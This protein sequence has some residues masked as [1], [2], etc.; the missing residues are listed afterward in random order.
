MANQS[1]HRPPFCDFLE[2]YLAA[3]KPKWKKSNLIDQRVGLNRFDK[4]L[5]DTNH[6]LEKL[7]WQ[8]LQEFY[9]FVNAQGI[10]PRSCEKSV[11]AAKQALRWGIEN[12][13]LPQ[14][15]EDIYVYHFPRHDWTIDL[16]Q[17]SKEFLS[18]LEPTRPG[19][20][21]SHSNTHRVFHTFLSEK[22]LTYRRLRAE[23]IAAFIKFLDQKGF[24]LHTK[25]QMSWQLRTYLRRL[26]HLKK[27][28]RHPDDIFPRHLIP[29][30]IISL[31]RPLDPDLDRRL[32]QILQE[33]D[34]IYYKAI[35]LLRRTGL[36][37]TEMRKLEFNCIQTDQKGRSSLIVPAIKL[38]RERRV[39]LD[40]DTIALIKTIQTMSIKN[41]RQKSQPKLLIIGPLGTTPRY[42]RYSGALT[43]LCA[44]LKVKKWINLHALRHTYATS[45][46]T[47][48]FSI[49]SLKEVLGHKS[50][51]MSLVY[52]KITPEKIHSEYSEAL[53]RM[54]N[55]HIPNLLVPK[56]GGPNAA[57]ADL[58][59][60]IGRA[61]DTCDDS[62]RRK[63]LIALRSRLAKLKMDLSKAM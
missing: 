30:N 9:R 42:E 33:T 44:R 32:Q 54:T 35:L 20:F 59:A 37:I 34:D 16:P 18:E 53:R 1:S 8:I 15:L 14:K 49:T 60:L 40:P 4:W 5:K 21:R 17:L 27:I 19:S 29:K 39:P 23:N 51:N 38:G 55:E 57:F 26:Y 36:R 28:S 61:L 12:G 6:P 10:Q 56:T 43:E 22:K 11:Q 52:A 50:I 24:V 63:R 41:Y 47:A 48:G 25:A 13:E 7:T 31:P 58:S 2:R 62:G 46:L 3:V 45:L